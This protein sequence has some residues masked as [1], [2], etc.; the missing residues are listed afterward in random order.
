MQE[1][2]QM[3]EGLQRPTTQF[4]VKLPG[5]FP[6][7]VKGVFDMMSPLA[8]TQ[9]E[10]LQLMGRLTDQLPALIAAGVAGHFSALLQHA[11][12]GVAGPQQYGLASQFGRNGVTIAIEVYAGMRSHQGK[13]DGARA[14]LVVL[15]LGHIIG[16]E[17]GK[18]I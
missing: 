15:A 12:P 4:Q 7:R 10:G 16:A 2:P 3:H 9:L 17:F 14:R 11:D 6:Q 1:T 5:F 8:A 13:K 18:F